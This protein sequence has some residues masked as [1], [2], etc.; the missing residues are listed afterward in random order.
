MGNL[1]LATIFIIIMNVLMI[2]VN[3]SLQIANPGTHFYNTNG[4]IIGNSINDGILNTSVADQLPS[5]IT[6]NVA[7][8]AQPGFGTDLFSMLKSWLLSLPGI[9]YIVD[10][11]SA[12][13]EI[14]KITGLPTEFILP[15][16]ALWDLLSL[17]VIVSWL[18]W[19]D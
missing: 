8:N 5:T 4:T 13:Y 2:F 11:V 14:L 1:T 3:M 17:L 9:K 16:A 18:A 10:I 12:P 7:A 6:G 19:R 15:I